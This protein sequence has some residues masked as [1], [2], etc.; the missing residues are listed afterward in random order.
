MRH[1]GRWLGRWTYLVFLLAWAGPVI[2][3]QWWVGGRQLWACRRPL[4][5]AVTLATL[6]LAAAD[7]LAIQRG[8]WTLSPQ[9]TLGLRLGAL[10]LEEALFFLATNLMVAQG[11][12]LLAR[13][14][15]LDPIGAVEVVKA[16]RAPV[17]RAPEEAFDI[18]LQHDEGGR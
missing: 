4:A 8:V 16:G 1:L 7:A 12:V 13:R 17:R 6:Y 9:R 2:G 10:P 3:L 18:R 15:L 11:L 5:L 14:P